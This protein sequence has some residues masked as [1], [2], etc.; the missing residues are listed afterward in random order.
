MR[1]EIVHVPGLSELAQTLNIPLSAVTRG[2]G[3]IF[4]SGTPPMDVTTGEIVKGGIEMQ[5]EAA[6]TAL[7]HC[8]AA[9]GAGFDDVLMVRIY[10]ANVGFYKAINRVYVRHF[11]ENPPAR[12][13]VPVAA[14]PMEFDL[15]IECVAVDPRATAA[16]GLA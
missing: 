13:F 11:P 1:R 6:L 15:E 16:G 2:G 4:V 9:A 5:T 12:T 7:K 14:W 3:M 8:L 10:A